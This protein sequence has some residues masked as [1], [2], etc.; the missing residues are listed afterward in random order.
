[1]IQSDLFI[2]ELR[3]I[4]IITTLNGRQTWRQRRKEERIESTIQSRWKE[5]EGIGWNVEECQSL[6]WIEVIIIKYSS[7]LITLKSK[8]DKSQSARLATSDH[9]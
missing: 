3:N 6:S 1:M 8:I 9:V 5:I 4:I 7:Q 2:M